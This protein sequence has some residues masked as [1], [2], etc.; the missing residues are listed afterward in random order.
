MYSG[1]LDSILSARVI[2]G[3][4][5][6]VIALHLY[7][8]FN[9]PLK[10]EIERG[11]FTGW[12]PAPSI[13]AGTEKL[14]IRLIALD[15][16]DEFI[17]VLHEPRYGYGSAV[18]PCIDCRIFALQKAREVMESEQAAFVFTGEVLGQRPMSQHRRALELIA[19]R[20]GLEGRLLRP[21]SALL[22]EPTIPERDGIVERSHLHG[23][24]GRSRKP[25]QELAARYGID[26]YPQSGGGCLLTDTSFGAKYRDFLEHSGGRRPDR[27][28]LMSLKTGRHLRLASGIKVIVGRSEAENNYL[29]QLLGDRCWVFDARDFSGASVFA[30]DE[31]CEEDFAGIASICARYGKSSSESTVAVIARKGSLTRQLEVKPAA[32]KD[33]EP[34]LI[35]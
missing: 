10:R 32:Q 13:T 8:G 18:N 26:W 14:G 33:I 12:T 4:G 25:Q 15:V 23:F 29:L 9:G 2:A 6:E 11:P 1:G 30:F 22:L 19:L 21:L 35:A 5:I 7:N 31:P 16:A 24:S 34:L 27:R 28:D 17:E 3:E 20:C